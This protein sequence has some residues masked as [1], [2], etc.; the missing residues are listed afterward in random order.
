MA[1]SRSEPDADDLTQATV[2]RAIARIS[3]WTPGTRLDSWLYKIAQNL[4]LN[5]RRRDA[6]R[7]RAAPAVKM[8]RPL[9]IQGG[10]EAASDLNR[11][12]ERIDSLP[13]EQ[14][15]VL[16]LVAVEGYGYAEA[17]EMIGAP[18]GT[19]TSRLARARSALR[20]E[21]EEARIEEK[22]ADG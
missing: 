10:A 13:A 2:E 12:R 11:L 3:Q 6:V 4:H 16:L 14:R 20:V 22:R 19:I 18:I 8:A 15:Q 1:L 5:E 7:E 9:S 21:A 17:A